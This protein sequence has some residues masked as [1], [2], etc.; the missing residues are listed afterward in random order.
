MKKILFMMVA[1]L[2]FVACEKEDS[3]DN[4]LYAGGDIKFYQNSE[5]IHRLYFDKEKGGTITIETEVDAFVLGM[6]IVT[7]DGK[8]VKNFYSS[9]PPDFILK[10]EDI[11]KLN[12]YECQGCKIVRDGFRKFTITVNPDFDYSK[13]DVAFSKIIESKEHGKVSEHGG[14]ILL[15]ESK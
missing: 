13:I 14:T 6:T 11:A 5:H 1:A 7:E 12:E 2:A 9:T 3:S 8:D 4:L 10:L 15:I